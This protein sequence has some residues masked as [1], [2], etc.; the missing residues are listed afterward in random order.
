MPSNR[1]ESSVRVPC[2]SAPAGTVAGRGT[3]RDRR[4][5]A[6]VLLPLGLSA[7]VFY[8][9]TKNY[10]F[11]DD[12]YNVFQIVNGDPLTYLITPY[13][14]HLLPARNFL[15][16]LSYL[17]FGTHA[18]GYFWVALAT[19]LINVA[20]L[21]RVIAGFTCSPPLAAFGAALWGAAPLHEGT[22][23]WHSVFGHVVVATCLLWMLADLAR[24]SEG[25]E[26]TRLTMVRWVLLLCAASTSFGIGLAMVVVFP[27]VVALFSFSSRW[28]WRLLACTGAVA[29]AVPVLYFSVL[30]AKS[31]PG[32]AEITLSFLSLDTFKIW[33]HVLTMLFQLTGYGVSSLL[34]GGLYSRIELGGMA[35]A[36]NALYLA[37]LAAGFVYGGG[38]TRRRILACGLL[39]L[40]AY[41]IVVAGRGMWGGRFY[42]ATRYQYVPL[43]PVTLGLCLA[44]AA[45]DRR[46]PLPIALKRSLLAAW[47]AAAAA[48]HFWLGRGIDN[49]L[50]ARKAAA[51]T[52]EEIRKL[53]DAAPA[54]Q[55][56]YIANRVFTGVGPLMI[57]N[58]HLFPGWAAA[59]TIFFPE[60][61]VDG[62]R[63]FFV[64]DDPVVLEAARHGRRTATLIVAPEQVPDRA[65]ARAR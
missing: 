36:L 17:L 11:A 3:H 55:D 5:T 48:A 39:C 20:L 38:E 33:D 65:R 43:L 53:V 2:A 41:G 24:V 13:G 26:P 8:P 22:L 30:R 21:F 49:H 60:N 61:I 63:V 12:L 59:F 42:L 14:G 27:L 28:R 47:I 50:F 52:V 37:V 4:R 44:L 15:F 40:A 23:G 62:K 35:Y 1:A 46:R 29:A 56:V 64:A 54:G 58:P 18:E 19:H 16:Y 25:A 51:R 10:F 7:L 32:G 6:W 34:L 31:P 57:K 45:L 9:I